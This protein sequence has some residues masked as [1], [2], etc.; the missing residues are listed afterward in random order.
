MGLRYIGPHWRRYS[1]LVV[2]GE[3]IPALS[4]ETL[5]PMT[6]LYRT[7]VKD[8]VAACIDLRGKTREN[9]VSVERLKALGV[10][11]ESWSND[12]AVY[13]QGLTEAI[14]GLRSLD[15]GEPG[16]S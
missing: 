4:I 11:L 7:A 15:T 5:G 3:T 10:T 12:V 6:L 1:P 13:R 14:L 2:S 16:G 8:D 9:A